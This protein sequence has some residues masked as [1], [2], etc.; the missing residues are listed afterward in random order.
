M[1]GRQL[2]VIGPV[3]RDIAVHLCRQHHFLPAP[4]T[5]REP[6]AHDL[7]SFAPAIAVGSVEE[8]DAGIEGAIHDGE[9]FRLARL[10]PKV[11]GAERQRTDEQAGTSEVAIIHVTTI[12]RKLRGCPEGGAER[13]GRAAR[14]WHQL[15]RST[16]AAT[17]SPERTA[18]SM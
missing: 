6:P 17:R 15:S 2:R 9:A 14:R 13:A 4:S 18:P 7:L 8:V 1:P 11:H 10:R 5:L 16:S 3:T 12:E